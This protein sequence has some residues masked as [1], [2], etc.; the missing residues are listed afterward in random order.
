[1]LVIIDTLRAD[2]LGC[3]GSFANVSPELDALAEKGVRFEQTIAQ[4]SWT[5]P[6]IGSMLT[7]I[8][9]RTLG[10]YDEGKERLADRFETLAESFKKHGYTTIG[11]TANPHINVVFGF[12]QGFDSYLDSKL[13]MDG[14]SKKK[15]ER[16]FGHWTAREIYRAAPDAIGP[17]PAPPYYVQLNIMEMHEPERSVRREYKGLFPDV[18]EKKT[19]RYLQALRQVSA[20]IAEFI[21]EFVSRP[22]M[23]DTLFVISSDH[24][25]GLDDHPG[26]FGG[27]FHGFLLY[28]SHARVPFIL[29]HPQGAIGRAVVERPVRNMD[30]MP[31]ILDLFGFDIPKGMDGV[32]VK[33]LI[34]DPEAEVDLPEYFVTETDFRIAEKIGVYSKEWKYFESATTGPG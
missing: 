18:K 30:L 4:C 16:S 15:R 19:R 31:T 25:E 1:V 12:D 6:S 32:S 21:E 13:G 7:G 22:G 29:Y 26:I 23:G 5:R 3:Y 24:G 11:A 17:D 33:A 2:K 8:Y 9:P 34:E 14:G 27:F 28:E 20:D 10:L